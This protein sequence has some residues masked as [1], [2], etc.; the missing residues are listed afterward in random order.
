MLDNLTKRTFFAPKIRG[1][2]SDEISVSKTLH[3][4]G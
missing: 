1:N 4:K 3:E 2:L